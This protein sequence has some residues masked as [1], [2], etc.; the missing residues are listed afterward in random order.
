LCPDNGRSLEKNEKNGDDKKQRDMEREFFFITG[1]EW[2][3]QLS[4]PK[5]RGVTECSEV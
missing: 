2:K 5:G 4:S 1:S 3:S